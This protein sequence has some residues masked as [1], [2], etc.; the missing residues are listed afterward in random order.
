ML[1]GT[2][3]HDSPEWHATRAKHVGSSEVAALFGLE[4]IQAYANSEF[5]LYHIKRGVKAPPV[6][7]ERIDAGLF[8]EDIIAKAAAKREN[9]KIEKGAYYEDDE[10]HGL[11]A[12][13]DHLILEPAPKDIEF[14]CIGPGVLECKNVDWL[15]HRAKWTNDEPPL[16]IMLQL[17]SQLACTG[18]QWGAVVA[19]VGGNHIEVYRF[20]RRPA[21]IQKMR[22]LV[23]EFWRRVRESDPPAPDSSASALHVLAE[24]FPDKI[25]DSV[26]FSTNNEWAVFCAQYVEASAREKAAATNKA[27]ARAHIANLM[28][29]HARGWG[30]GYSV[31]RSVTADTPDRPAKP[32]EIIKGRAGGPRYTVKETML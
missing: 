17:Q 21:L 29:N 20:F 14:G 9:W 15:I 8:L 4:A 32:G 1:I 27:E 11:G 12:S 28:G 30:A 31:S 10:C 25:D 3:I 2:Y 19:L 5:A 18:C 26:D 23:H 7:G 22:D 6:E 13:L 24:L 16:P